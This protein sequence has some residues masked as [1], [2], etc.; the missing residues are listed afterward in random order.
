MENK[1]IIQVDKK[2]FLEVLYDAYVFLD[3]YYGLDNL[4]IKDVKAFNDILKKYDISLEDIVSIIL[5]K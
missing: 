3:E 5:D 2:D 1:D 4:K